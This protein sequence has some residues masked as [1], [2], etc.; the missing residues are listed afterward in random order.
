MRDRGFGVQIFVGAAV[1]AITI[2]VLFA[3]RLGR[4]PEAIVVSPL[5]G[6]VAPAME[7]R[8]LEGVDVVDLGMLRGKITVVNFW[9][10]W[11]AGCRAEHA[12]LVEAAATFRDFGVQF[13]GVL[14]QDDVADGVRFLD[15]LGRGDAFL[16]VHDSDSRVGLEYGVLGL[17][18]TF[19]INAKGDIVGKISG[20]AS[21]ELL[22]ATVQRLV[23]SE[24]IG[25]VKAGEVESR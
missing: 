11:C 22:I 19:F 20:P 2:G 16:Y 23:L 10:S 15:E 7:V 21:R 24:S 17:P 9:A 4:N 12:G 13:V 5:I 18:E 8:S 3:D 6:R 25:T 1:I 14:H